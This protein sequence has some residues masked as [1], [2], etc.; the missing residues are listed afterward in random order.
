MSAKAI[1]KILE[2][3]S[4]STKS[5]C[6]APYLHFDFDQSGELHSCYAGKRNLG[7]WKVNSVYKEFNS[8]A[9]QKLRHAQKIG[10]VDATWPNCNNCIKHE[11]HK[12]ESDRLR[13]L[14]NKY[15]ELGHD[16]F[17]SLIEKISKLDIANVDVPEYDFVEV[18][19]SNY[20]NLR[21]M[22]CDHRSSTQWL[23]ALTN[24]DFYQGAKESG[25]SIHPDAN[26]SNMM[27][28]FSDHQPT[29][30][31]NFDEMIK[32]MQKSKLITFSGGEPFLDPNYFPLMNEVIKSPSC[33]EKTLDIH[34]NLNISNIEKHFNH[35]E[36]F[37]TVN[38]YASIDV[39][40]STYAYFRRLGDWNTV[41]K[42]IKIIQEFAK[43]N[44]HVN[45]IGH[46]TFGMFGALRYKEI[47]DTWYALQLKPNTNIIVEGPTSAT[48]LPQPLKK[49][50]ITVM[51]DVL[52]NI[53]YSIKFKAITH[54]LRTYLTNTPDNG[55]IL[56]HDVLN[57]CKTHD[58]NTDLNTLDFY[59]ELEMYYNNNND[60]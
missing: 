20:C 3:Y 5:F 10:D 18:R 35:W 7:N 32:V 34:T 40:P 44:K 17:K 31:T 57:W 29:K 45:M 4:L 30:T 13:N 15:M 23:N 21:C 26:P 47:A 36:K 38:I 11:N 48:Y 39:P 14:R 12:V 59:P 22:H 24:E 56:H 50:V 60:E 54:Q 28:F 58:K 2:E 25:A 8:E 42:N 1:N 6:L 27:K 49:S 41:E 33:A 9:Y 37:E 52:K 55:D 19:L 51:D 46:I 16:G 43:T 53:K